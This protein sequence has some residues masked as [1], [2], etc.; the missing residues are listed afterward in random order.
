[1]S[2][3][4]NWEIS[5][6][7]YLARQPSDPLN[8]SPKPYACPASH[9]GRDRDLAHVLH[10]AGHHQVGGAAEHRLG[11]EV[12]RLLGRAALPVHGDAGNRLGQAGRE[13]RG[14][15]D[16]AGLRADGVHAAEHDVVHGQRVHAGAGQQRRDDV[17]AEIGRVRAGQPAAAAADRGPDRIDQE[18]LG[19]RDSP[20]AARLHWLEHV[21]L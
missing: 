7:P 2:A 9:R 20:R 12:D 11:R 17:R 4:R 13:P 21:L 18:R 1:M 3:A 16:V 19:H 14:A 10:P 6:S 15:G 5:W 8:G